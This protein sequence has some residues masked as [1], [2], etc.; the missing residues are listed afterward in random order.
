MRVDAIIFFH[1]HNKIKISSLSKQEKYLLM[2]DSTIFKSK[3]PK[4]NHA[5]VPCKQTIKNILN[6]SKALQV[7]RVPSYGTI[8]F[9]NN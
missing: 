8:M 4:I 3:Q 5:S 9:M 6:Y 2:S 7:K 1:L